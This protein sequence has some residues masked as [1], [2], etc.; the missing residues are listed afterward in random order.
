MITR[1]GVFRNAP[2]INV[3]VVPT[4]PTLELACFCDMPA[5]TTHM[6]D[7]RLHATTPVLLPLSDKDLP[8][9]TLPSCG[10]LWEACFTFP[11]H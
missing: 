1:F 2:V 7:Q 6:E 10:L 3:V 4:T 11:L 8:A 9:V 5:V